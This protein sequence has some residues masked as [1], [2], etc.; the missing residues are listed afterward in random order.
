MPDVK[1]APN[2]SAVHPWSLRL[3]NFLAST[4]I[5]GMACSIYAYS[6]FNRAQLDR[7][8]GS[9]EV[10]VFS[11]RQFLGWAALS[12]IAALALYLFGP[13]EPVAS[14]SLRSLQALY[15][16]L[17]SPLK[18][19][20]QG[21]D[22]EDGLALRVTLLKVFFAPLM[23]MSLMV[24]CA[25]AWTNG[26]AIVGSNSLTNSSGDLVLLFNRFGYWFLIQAILFIDTLVFTVGYL[27][28]S[29]RLDNQIR[30]VDPSL[31]GWATALI[32]YPPF[33]LITQAI[34]GSQISDFP[35][36]EPP[37]LHLL[38]NLLI[39]TLMGIYMA[40]SV[41]LGLKASNLTH[42]GIVSRG[43]YRLVR[44][45]AYTCKNMAWWIAAVP[46]VTQAFSQSTM[47]G[48][49]A[50]ASVAGWS[51]IYVLRALTEEDHLRRVDAEYD[52]YASRVRHRFI[53]GLI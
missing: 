30:S 19:W 53:P 3:S 31:L 47:D 29:R 36:F 9:P 46:L 4:F 44:H 21:I 38:L 2:P 7:L 17:R 51:L 50:L 42:R 22:P 12:Y 18:S 34:L 28:E 52:A 39:L 37:W 41:A 25:S 48:L 5:V 13:A 24:F 10:L 43:P 49:Q 23:G 1:H 45:P 8:F 15:A 6:P 32:C 11:G 33:N 40:A 27:L 26:A 14:K 16:W 20:R 35:Q